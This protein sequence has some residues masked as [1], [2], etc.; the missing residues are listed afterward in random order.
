MKQLLASLF[1]SPVVVMVDLAVSS[2]EGGA[3][4]FYAKCRF[5]P[6]GEAYRGGLRMVLP[7]SCHIS[8]E[9]E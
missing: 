3:M 7:R 5:A 2:A 6:T 8:I 9:S 1:S 4:D